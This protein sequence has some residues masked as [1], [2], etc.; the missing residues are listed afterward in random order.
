MLRKICS[1]PETS[2]CSPSKDETPSSTAAALLTKLHSLRRLAPDGHFR[3]YE[4]IFGWLS[5]LLRSTEAKLAVPHPKSLF[6]MCL[7]RFPAA[8]A[9]IEAWD[10]H[11]AEE[12]GTL[13]L[14][15]SSNASVEL[16]GQLESFGSAEL[17]WKPLKLV[18]RAHALSMLV[19]AVKEGLFE[20]EFVSLLA[21]LY[22]SF[23]CSQDAAAIVKGIPSQLAKPHS[24]LSTLEDISALQP[25]ATIVESLQGAGKSRAGFECLSSLIK[26][27]KLP[28]EWLYTKGFQSVWAATLEALSTGRPEP[29]AATFTCTVVGQLSMKTEGKDPSKHDTKK[30]ALVNVVAGLTGTAVA[31]ERSDSQL[32]VVVAQR[33]MHVLDRCISH[34]Q[35][36]TKAVGEGSLLVLSTARYIAMARS[37]HIDSTIRTQAEE[38]CRQQLVADD[39]VSSQAQYR[40]A[41]FLVCSIAQ[42][43]RRACSMAGRDALTEICAKLNHVGLPDWFHGGLRMDGAFLLAQKT[44]DLRDLAFAERLPAA[45]RG[46]IENNTIFSGWRWEEG[47]SEWVLRSPVPKAHVRNDENT[48]ESLK[49]EA[50]TPGRRERERGRVCVRERLGGNRRRNGSDTSGV[51]KSPID[52]DVAEDEDEGGD[53][54]SENSVQGQ[55][56]GRHRGEDD[57][58]DELC[59]GW[60]DSTGI[61]GL[62]VGNAARTSVLAGGDSDPRWRN[63]VRGSSMSRARR[64]GCG[65]ENW[66]EDEAA[67]PAMTRPSTTIRKGRK[68]LLAG[69][70][71]EAS[72]FEASRSQA[73]QHESQSRKSSSSQ[74]RSRSQS[75]SHSRSQALL[76]A[77]AC[78]RGPTKRIKRAGT[79]TQAGTRGGTVRGMWKGDEGGGLEGGGNVEERGD[80]WDELV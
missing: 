35:A 42:C 52:S 4:A 26:N 40:E 58:G 30:Q 66:N 2:T 78:R 47:I 15:D 10:R 61:C 76:G 11:D 55:G 75:P 27:E 8:L 38:A 74:T 1:Q 5:G 53:G 24:S 60:E 37:K 56:Q 69:V 32:G 70:R 48:S 65:T 64:S 45:S 39:G 68:R 6:G 17:G 41:L 46:L 43:Q 25:V 72:L 14:W 36:E 71:G 57:S 63:P 67:S 20:P 19:K 44:N 54:E 51:I 28:L 3:I 22:L 80:D 79:R 7:Q 13:S 50:Q 16:Y 31:F 18:V 59:G 73:S 34:L 29:S 9:E 49:N 23:K 62:A 77:E 12:N 33:L 21:E